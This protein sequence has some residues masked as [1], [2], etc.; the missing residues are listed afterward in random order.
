VKV[1]IFETFNP[2]VNCGANTKTCSHY[3]RKRDQIQILAL[4]EVHKT[5]TNNSI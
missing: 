4:Y 2:K 3:H 5:N 1:P